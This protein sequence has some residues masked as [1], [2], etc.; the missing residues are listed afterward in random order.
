VSRYVPHPRDLFE[1]SMRYGKSADGG[2][3]AGRL[4]VHADSRHPDPWFLILS[5]ALSDRSWAQIVATYGQWF[6]CKESYKDQKNDP[7]AGFR[8][9]CVKLGTPVRWDR[10]W[11][12][13]A[14][15]YYWRNI[16]GW[17]VEVRG[18]ARHWR[19]NTQKTRTHA[20]C[21]LGHW[22]LEHH[23]LRWRLIVRHQNGFR[24]QVP[25]IG[26]TAVPT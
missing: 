12:L 20:L 2:T 3:Y 15:A 13:F 10:L 16:A 7:F 21:P 14:W 6:R 9:D 23:D 24:Q 5:A 26:D 8:L 1:T 19:A 18:E 17:R 25:P 22:A 11:L 4:V